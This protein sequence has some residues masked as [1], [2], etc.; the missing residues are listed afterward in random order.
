MKSFGPADAPTL[1]YFPWTVPA[2][3]LLAL[4]IVAAY[5]GFPWWLVAVAAAVALVVVARRQP[6]LWLVLPLL[7]PLGYG[8][9][10][11]WE[12]QSDPLAPLIA[13]SMTVSGYADGR[14]LTIDTI[15]GDARYRGERVVLSPA[16]VVGSGRVTLTGELARPQGKRNP[17]GFDYRGYLERRGVRA[18]LFVREVHAFEPGNVT[19][20]ERL[21]QGVIAGLEQREAALLQAMT[22]GVREDLG[23]LREIFT[24][25]GLAHLLALS[26]LHVGVLMLALGLALRPLGSVRY[27]LMIAFALF[28]VVLVG[29]TPSVVRAG[30]MASAVLFALW[31]GGGRLEPWPALG[32]AALLTLLWNPSWLFDISFQLSY[33]AVAGILLFVEPVM[34][35][36]FGPD[37][38]VRHWWDWRAL[39][40]GAVVVS[41]SAQALTVPLI[42]HAFGSVP[43][44]SPLVNVFAIPLAMLLVPLGFLAGVAGLLSPALAGLLG[45]V[46]GLVASALIALADFASKLPTLTWG[47]IEPVGFALYAIG[48]LALTLALRKALAPWRGLVVVIVAIASSMVLVDRHGSEI[49]FLDVGQGDG[50]VIRLPR[51]ATILVDGGGSVWSDFDVGARVVV[52][53]LKALGVSRVDLMVATH[54]HIDHMEGLVSVLERV[55]VGQLVIG[56]ESDDRQVFQ[57]LIATAQRRGVPIVQVSRGESLVWG[58]VRLDILNPPQRRYGG[59]DADSVA[60]ALALSGVPRALFLGDLPVEVERDIA[61][62]NVDVLMVPHHGSRHATS[63]ALLRAAN[64][65][66]AVISY[67]R[68]NYGHPHPAVLARLAQQGIPVRETFKEGAIRVPLR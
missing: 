35:A 9:Y 4:G 7:V 58:E 46:T 57:D 34:K 10:A 27:P 24:A 19:L 31:L 45:I 1:P 67:G 54:A 2:A 16:G 36:I 37:F 43:L 20:R 30:L 42:A 29:A 18:Q 65:N 68:N 56:A 22:L 61:F 15:D 47:E 64:P 21:R 23:E 25:S 60:F 48:A 50:V 63:E 12:A 14:Y 55:P 26:G 59:V 8:R 44:F 53:A 39:T 62:P 49:V 51:G 41:A 6:R 13:Q 5:H 40:V 28:F 17:G 3:L 38:R 52:P 66:L 11:Q 33:L 32:L